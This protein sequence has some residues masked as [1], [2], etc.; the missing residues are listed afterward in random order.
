M[1]YIIQTPSARRLKEEILDSVVAKVDA[2]GRGI[3]SWQSVETDD[4]E[5]VLVH[6]VDQWAEKGC[7]VLRQ[8]HGHNDLH[9]R[10]IYWDSC[11]DRSSDDDKYLLGRFTELLLVHF[12]YFVDKVVIE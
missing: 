6:T 2:D 5:C 7:I 9:V 11:D 4:G 12:S 1:N 10:F 3:T 8:E